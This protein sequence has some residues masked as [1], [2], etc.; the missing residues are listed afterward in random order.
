[1]D[2]LDGSAFPNMKEIRFKCENGV[3][4]VAFAFNP[5]R[6]ALIL[7]IGNKKG[8]D[9][10]RFYSKLVADADRQFQAHLDGLAKIGDSHGKNA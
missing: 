2:T 5:R 4:R 7:T 6:T 9:Q 8:K 1:M 3:W 10:E